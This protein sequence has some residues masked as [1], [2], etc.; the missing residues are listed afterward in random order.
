MERLQS[1]DDTVS[2]VSGAHLLEQ[3]LPSVV[4][5]LLRDIGAMAQGQGMT[6]YAVGGFV[7]DL[8]LGAPTLDV[9][10]A[11]EG[12]GVALATAVAHRWQ[13]RL[14][15]HK[16]FLTAT[17]QWMEHLSGFPL[18]RVD[19]ATARKERY[20]QPAVLPEVE[21]ASIADDLWRRDFSIN[22][23]ALCLAPD[24]F[25]EL[26][27]LTGG[28]T[29]L[30]RGVIRALHDRSF[31]DD[32]TRIFRAVR[33]EQ[34]FGFRIEPR[35]FRLLLS[36][37]MFLTL[38]TRDRIKHELW[39]VL[40][41]REPEKPLQRLQ[42]LSVL[43]LTVPELRVTPRRLTWLKRLRAWLRWC[44]EHLPDRKVRHEWAL[45]L[46]LLSNA[47][48][49]TRFCHRF[50]LSERERGDALALLQ[51]LRRPTPKRPSGF[52]WWLNPLSLEGALA[53]A[54]R[55]AGVADL[56]WRRYFLEWR[57]AR[58]DITGDDLKA[59]G[60]SGRS[61]AV[62]LKAALSVKLNRNADAHQQLRAALRAVRRCLAKQRKSDA[63]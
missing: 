34:R 45:L 56:L 50:Q 10:I 53:V 22:A 13:G 11:V 58:P 55:R 15:V 6:A 63:G 23:M 20:P 19:I 32:P 9:D 26:I 2:A 14:T 18:Q 29:D 5:A 42:R 16:R 49:V 39:R 57:D 40:Q 38:L 31:I 47:E 3:R 12:N 52:V 30:Q 61:I 1:V 24:R 44:A 33:Y 62:G 35:T 48:A 25:G 36:A 37:K 21:P 4:V 60:I 27:D 17:V 43:A 54:A 41:E 51:A 59:F 7:R 8:L 28:Y 46:P